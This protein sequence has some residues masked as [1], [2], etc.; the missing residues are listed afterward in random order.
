MFGY[1]EFMPNTQTSKTL[2]E[3]ACGG[4]G[5][6][7]I[8]NNPLCTNSVFQAGGP[9]SNQL[10]RVSGG[11]KLRS[12]AIVADP[13]ASLYGACS[14]GYINPEHTPLWSDDP[15]WTTASIRLW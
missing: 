15:T 11:F 5:L 6:V 3:I 2:A 13:I 7:A 14:S 4:A 1:N 10:N 8:E 9:E 12:D